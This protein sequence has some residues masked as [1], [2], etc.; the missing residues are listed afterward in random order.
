MIWNIQLDTYQRELNRYNPEYIEDT[1]KAF[2][3]DSILILNLLSNPDF[4]ENENIK[5][6]AA[7]KNVDSWLSLFE[8]SLQ[9]KLD[10]CKK[11]ENVFLKEFSPE[12][13]THIVRE[14]QSMV[15]HLSG[16]E[17]NQFQ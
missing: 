16:M 2:F 12:F 10:F 6:F 5:L 9:E 1:E 14:F 15:L 4:S 7:V 17:E 3:A 8:L 11:L 13:K